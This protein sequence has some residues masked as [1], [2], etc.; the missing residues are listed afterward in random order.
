[1]DEG[2]G[3]I[4]LILGVVVLLAFLA[5]CTKAESHEFYDRDCC[6]QRHCHAVPDGMVGMDDNGNVVVK[7]FSSSHMRTDDSRVRSSQDQNDH[8]CTSDDGK[9]LY[10]VYRAN[11]GM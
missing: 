2:T 5:L 1:M 6:E 3:R 11:R 9:Q 7:G 10:C 8:I 4:T